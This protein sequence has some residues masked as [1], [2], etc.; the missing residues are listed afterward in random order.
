MSTDNENALSRWLITGR[1]LLHFSHRVIGDFIANRG[2]LLA[3]G[4][5]YNALLSVI[6]LFAVLASVLSYLVEPA[7]VVATFR[8]QAQFIAPGHT[9]LIVDTVERILNSRDVFGIMG[10]MA[11]LFFSSLAFR[12][13]D[14][15]IAIIFHRKFEPLPRKLWLSLLLPYAF[16]LVLGIAI[17]ILTLTLAML[18]RISEANLSLLGIEFTLGWAPVT[19]MY[20]S[21]F[22]GISLFFTAIYKVLPQ[23]R[24]ALPRAFIGGFTAA[25]L[26]EL[27]L[28]VLMYYFDKI[29]L[30][31][32]IY[33]S[34]ATII[35][36]LLSLEMGAVI[37]LLGAQIIAELE[38]NAAAGVKWYED[39]SVEVEPK[40]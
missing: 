4:V 15:A 40:D 34:F 31:G 11:L 20:V 33:G 1:R 18:N 39:V 3:G 8:A 13:L 30:V 29:S 26:W 28:R 6:P 37:V 7:Q 17:L 12:M 25:T 27:L 23:T 32:T 21:G 36:V 22:L 35:V 14:D 10:V 9:A 24:V 5:G 16:V 19:V 38:R 2:L